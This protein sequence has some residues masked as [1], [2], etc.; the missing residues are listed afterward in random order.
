MTIFVGMFLL[1]TTAFADWTGSTREPENSKKID[2]KVFYVITNA[3]ELAWFAEL[4]CRHPERVFTKGV[5]R[6]G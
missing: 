6:W 5:D 2:G 4:E 1:A 3:E